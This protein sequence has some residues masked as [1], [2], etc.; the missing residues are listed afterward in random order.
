MTI[1]PTGSRPFSFKVPSSSPF[2]SISMPRTLTNSSY[3]LNT[4]DFHFTQYHPQT[5]NMKSSEKL[6]PTSNMVGVMGCSIFML[7][8]KSP[9]NFNIQFSM[10]NKFMTHVYDVALNTSMHQYCIISKA[11][12]TGHRNS[13]KHHIYMIFTVFFPPYHT[14]QDD[15]QLNGEHTLQQHLRQSIIKTQLTTN[16]FEGFVTCRRYT[17]W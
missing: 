1:T 11:P 3:R 14:L 9:Y 4:T 12:P 15:M 17:T 5:L 7:C 10:Y 8:H 6:L 2:W 13:H 16:L